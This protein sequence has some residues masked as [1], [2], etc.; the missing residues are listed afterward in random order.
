MHDS[1]SSP[2]QRSFHSYGEDWHYSDFATEPGQ[3]LYRWKVNELFA[4]TAL[5]LRLAEDG[6]DVGR[7]VHVA[8]EARADLTHRI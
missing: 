7:L 6:D 3:A 2:R 4:R 8:D 5:D 1:V